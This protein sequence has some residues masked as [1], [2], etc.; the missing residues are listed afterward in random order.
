MGLALNRQGDLFASDNQGNYTPFNE[1]NH[2]VASK[3]YGFI[4]KLEV[5]PDFSPPFQPAAVDIPHPWARSVNGICFLDTPDD[6]RKKTGRDLF[7]PFEGHVLGCEY[8]TLQLLR[9]SLEKI[10]DTYQGA[11]YPLSREPAAGEPT[12][13][14]PICCAIAPDG[15]I[16][17][18]N[19]R[20]SAWGAGRN[21]GSIVRLRP[22]G[23][24]PCG[25]AEV[26]ANADGF[27]LHFTQPVVAEEAGRAKN[28]SIVSFRRIPTPAYGGADVDEQPAKIRNVEVSP[29]CR[30][31]RLVL[32]ALRPGFV[33]EFQLHAALAPGK[34]LFP[35]EAYYTL[36]Q[37]PK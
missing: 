20:D 27:T 2:L 10:G 30:Q 34:Q 17:V 9:M 15:D 3:R 26:R 23:E 29:D 37:A 11:V 33:Y 32:D 24:L 22:S 14:G 6:V 1:L 8:T 25:L 16:Y 35:A 19:L 5:K 36:R 13:E 28:Y 18:G 12:F 7:G 21:T 4:N 31:V